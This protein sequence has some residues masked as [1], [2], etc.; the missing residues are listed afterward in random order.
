MIIHP[1]SLEAVTESGAIS[2]WMEK[3]SIPGCAMAVIQKG[4]L[5]WSGAFGV[6]NEQGTPMTEGVL[7]ECA[8]LTK[9]LFALLAMQEVDAGKLDLDAPIV[10]ILREEIWSQD[11]RFLCI[12]PRQCLCHGSGL[13][14]WENRPMGMK[15]D[16]GTQF[17][18]SGEGY[19]LLQHLVEQIEEKSMEQLFRERFFG[20]FG[21]ESSTAYW[22]PAVS[23][24][25]SVGFGKDG[26]VRKIRNERR[27]SG[28]AP[29]PNA[30]WSLYSYAGDYARFL[31]AMIEKRGNLSPAAFAEMTRPQNRADDQMD[32]ALGFGIPRAAPHVLWHWGDNAGFQSFAIWDRETGDGAVINTN[33]DRGVAFYMDA[34]KYLTDAVFLDDIAAFIRNAE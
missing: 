29:E 23:A 6:R 7:F 21:M 9:S 30:A 11:P 14:N 16:P 19:F 15:F 27:V 25:F 8:S 5:T 17:S 13:P 18:Y 32:W 22:T 20:P 28:N 26:A 12:T 24:A 3:H 33:S 4:K 2:A 34:L 10:P 1:S 31:C